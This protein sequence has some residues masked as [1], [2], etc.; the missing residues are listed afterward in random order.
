MSESSRHKAE[1]NF[2]P[3][4]DDDDAVAVAVG[5]R[6]RTDAGPKVLATGRGALA[7]RIVEIAHAAGV[8]VREDEDLAQLLVVL[9]ED[10]DIPLEAFEAVS[11]ILSYVYRANGEARPETA[12]EGSS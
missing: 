6:A 2:R 8:K 7:A 5:H 11:E 9:E 10:S 12:S 3:I 1:D 4:R